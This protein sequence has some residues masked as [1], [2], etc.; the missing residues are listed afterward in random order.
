MHEST[1]Q[2]LQDTFA[3]PKDLSIK[4][5]AITAGEHSSDTIVDVEWSDGHKSRY[6]QPFLANATT[7]YERRSVIRQGQVTH[8]LWDSTVAK[9]PPKVTFQEATEKN[10]STVLKEIV[11]NPKPLQYGP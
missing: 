7:S 10:M 3:I 2:R 1:K 4:S 5:A 8:E 6:T 9:H 11:S